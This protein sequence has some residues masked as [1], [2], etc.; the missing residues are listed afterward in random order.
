MKFISVCLAISLYLKLGG[1]LS[2]LGSARGLVFRESDSL[3]ISIELILAVIY[4]IGARG[5]TGECGRRRK[6]WTDGP[7]GLPTPTVCFLPAWIIGERQDNGQQ[8]SAW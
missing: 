3:R 2:H 1:E 6:G 4:L 8:L 5:M 7:P